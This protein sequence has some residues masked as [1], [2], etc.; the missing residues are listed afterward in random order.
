MNLNIISSNN[1]MTGRF[2]GRLDNAAVAK[3]S[4]D[5]RMLADNA[6]KHIILDCSGLQFISLTGMQLF[7]QLHEAA[8]ARGGRIS[9]QGVA[10]T[11]MQLFT[12]T[13]F[14]SLLNFE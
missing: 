6:D 5:M 10:A 11:L 12:A 13:G 7:H 4:L 2:S 8:A 3:A 9:I 1:T 14:A